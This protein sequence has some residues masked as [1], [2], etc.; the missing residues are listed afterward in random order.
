MIRH[1]VQMM[2]LQRG[3]AKIAVRTKHIVCH[4]AQEL[5]ASGMIFEREPQDHEEQT[6]GVENWDD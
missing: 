6:A 4:K 1:G 3:L 2:I 5:T